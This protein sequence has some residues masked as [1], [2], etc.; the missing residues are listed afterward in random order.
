MSESDEAVRIFENAWFRRFARRERISD[1]T[2]KDAVANAEK[3]MIDADLG[4]NV[5]KQGF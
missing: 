5:I 2:L 1:K 4:G 3:G